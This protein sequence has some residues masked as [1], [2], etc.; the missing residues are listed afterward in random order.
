M[1]KRLLE[2]IVC[3]QCG[4]EFSLDSFSEGENGEIIDGRLLCKGCDRLFPIIGGIPRLLPDALRDLLL[5]HHNFFR[6]YES[7]FPEGYFIQITKDT[8]GTIQMK[9]TSSSFG[10]EWTM[11]PKFYKQWEDNFK[12]YIRPLSPSFFK[13]K[14]G[15]DVGCGTGRHL[16]FVAQYGAE[17]VGIDLSEAVQVAYNNTLSFFNAHVVQADLYHPPFKT[18]YFDF[19]YSFGVLHH[20]PEPEAGFKELLRFL[21]RNGHISIY[22]YNS[23]LRENKIKY[24][25]LKI[26]SVFRLMTTR[27]PF[28]FLHWLCYPL[29]FTIYCFVIYP[30]KILQFLPKGKELA[31]YLPFGAYRHY[32]MGVLH[33]DLFDRFSAPIENRYTRGEVEKWFKMNGLKNIQIAEN[34]GWVGH[35][36]KLG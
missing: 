24:Y 9:K 34:Y 31:E 32:P 2:L 16:Y 3:P 4:G 35:G 20:L 19:I 8:E 15:L 10:F 26:A 22:L 1:K 12:A 25:L 13:N 6:K 21:K 36:D 33:N 23:Y 18:K 7:Q 29:A 28:R 11:F 14:R 17:V 5:V 30:Y 27:L